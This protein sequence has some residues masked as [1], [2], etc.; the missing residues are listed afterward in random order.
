MILIFSAAV[1]KRIVLEFKINL[2]FEKEN[3]A[4]TFTMNL[5]F[6]NVLRISEMIEMFLQIQL[7]NV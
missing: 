5:A 1:A 7:G 6:Y 3:A 2:L 4:I